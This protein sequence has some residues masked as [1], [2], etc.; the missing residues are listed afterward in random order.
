MKFP[1]RRFLRLAAG[2]AALPAVP[3]SARWSIPIDRPGVEAQEKEMLA[4][5]K[6]P[7]ES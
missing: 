7:A 5:Q 6:P 2:V 1:R 4:Q 3:S